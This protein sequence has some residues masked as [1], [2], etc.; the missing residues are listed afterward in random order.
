MEK[1]QF[2]TMNTLLRQAIP[3]LRVWRAVMA[4]IGG[5]LLL[6]L[7][8]KVQVPFWPVPMTMQTFAVLMMGALCGWRLG[9]ATVIAWLAL[10]AGLPVLSEFK[11]LAL[12]TNTA[13]YLAAFPLMAAFVGWA[14]ERGWTSRT[15]TAF[16]TLLVAEAICFT[17]GL[18]W[19]SS[20]IGVDKAIQFG[21]LPFALGDLVKTLLA[22]AVI[23]AARRAKQA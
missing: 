1:T 22:T 15:A 3:D 21:F 8:A 19:L 6:T 9:L 12:A 4:V 16:G 13:G 10:A 17:L 18:G 20:L 23:T 11:T 14:A 5:S 7:S 2:I